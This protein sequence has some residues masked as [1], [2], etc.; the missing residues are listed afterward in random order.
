MGA[1]TNGGGAEDDRA[2]VIA[3]LEKLASL[4][5]HADRRG[6]MKLAS[7][8]RATTLAVE[9]RLRSTELTIVIAGGPAKRT[10]LNALAGDELFV[11]DAPQPP[12]SFLVMRRARSVGWVARKYDGEIE[13]FSRSHP[14]RGPWFEREIAKAEKE[15]E[16][17]KLRVTTLDVEL[18]AKEETLSERRVRAAKRLR[19][20]SGPFDRARA[21]VARIIAWILGVLRIGAR[22]QL[23][24]APVERAPADG[25]VVSA[26]IARRD[27]ERTMEGAREALERRTKEIERMRAE[28]AK[29][30]EERRAAFIADVRALTNANQRGADIADLTIEV[31]YG[32]LPEGIAIIDAPAAMSPLERADPDIRKAHLRELRDRAG[33]CVLVAS[34]GAVAVG[35]L[36][37]AVRPIIPHV[38][39]ATD[40]EAFEALLPQTLP[41]LFARAREE[42]SLS[43]L[44]IAVTDM[45]SRMQGLAAAV[46]AGEAELETR[47]EALERERLPEP[48]KFREE[49]LA[50]MAG[51]IE[52]SVRRV[53]KRAQNRLRER[54]TQLER[55]W[56]A[57]IESATDRA[58]VASTLAQI[59]ATVAARV[60]G[61]LEGIGDDI[62][63]E[64][65]ST[66]EVLEV[67]ALEDVRQRYK[68]RVLHRDKT[69]PVVV[70]LPSEEIA[71]LRG[72]PL[73]DVLRGITRWRAGLAFG[74]VA[75]ATAI[76]GVMDAVT[77]AAIGVG[78]GIAGAALAYF[79]P[80][81]QR[82]KDE[83]IRQIRQRVAQVEKAIGEWID[84]SHE[85]FAR[86]IRAAIDDTLAHAL[87]KRDQSIIRL[88]D[89]EGKALEREQAKLR[90]LGDLKSAL[91][92]HATQFAR[93]AERSASVLREHVA[94]TR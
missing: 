88:I 77:G 33:G 27:V 30:R 81:V 70:E 62:G 23:A 45:P 84:R 7:A 86:D 22:A 11:P 82:M 85:S 59:D 80:R 25:R 73:V 15:L 60:Q 16:A 5:D 10:L 49:Q 72:P 32:I 17:A 24:P 94:R 19:D 4:A 43:V 71:A 48:A 69:A 14:D 92:A 90:D 67:W 78:F 55:E 64:M 89:L 76:G 38:L 21:H 6:W 83:C 40:A 13:Q 87:K 50:K 9:G 26:M 8:L 36:E 66:S 18:T 3:A 37:D 42:E 34:P 31:A 20:A 58:A 39:D 52:E 29:H 28:A 65:Q 12:A 61:L 79:V 47:I 57:A 56:L 93:I 46:A 53:T 1:V 68:T 41:V 91:D 2:E 44:A 74:S 35:D 51:A 63:S 54:C 75:V